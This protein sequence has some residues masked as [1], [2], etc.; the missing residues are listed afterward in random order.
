MRLTRENQHHYL[1]NVIKSL[2]HELNAT[3][4]ELSRLANLRGVGPLDETQTNKATTFDLGVVANE[5][6]ENLRISPNDQQK[7]LF[8]KLEISEANF[9]I[10]N[11]NSKI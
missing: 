4:M 3:K 7:Q 8:Y 1:A 5:S 6:S 11:L 2:K 10:K 9:K